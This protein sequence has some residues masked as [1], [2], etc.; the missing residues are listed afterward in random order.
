[1]IIIMHHRNCVARKRQQ[2]EGVH[3]SMRI[4][5]EFTP[6]SP[7]SVTFELHLDDDDVTRVHMG[8]SQH[9]LVRRSF[10]IMLPDVVQHMDD[11]P[12][13]TWALVVILIVHPFVGSRLTLP[14]SVSPALAYHYARCG[15]EVGP[16]EPTLAAPGSEP[17]S[18]AQ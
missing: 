13:D 7:R 8:R 14:F 15:K 1:M 18:A 9:E 11:L 17:T 12:R 5:H 4:V 10:R 3:R 2:S 6:A 16:I